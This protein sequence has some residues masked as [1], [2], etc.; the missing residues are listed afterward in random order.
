VKTTEKLDFSCMSSAFN[1]HP[2][3]FNS[4]FTSLENNNFISSIVVPQR[5]G[6]YV[7]QPSMIAP[8]PPVSLIVYIYLYIFICIYIYLCIIYIL[9]RP[10]LKILKF[11]H[12]N[13]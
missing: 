4:L 1:I 8:P 10:F 6:Q 3:F 13:L 9:N 11:H 12:Q 5:W 2:P 7:S